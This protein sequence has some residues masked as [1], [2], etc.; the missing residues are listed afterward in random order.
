[1]T[2]HT[3]L[4]TCIW[5]DGAAEEAVD[6]YVS[7]FP[8]ASKGFVMKSPVDWPGGSAGDIVLVNFTL[9]EQS[10]QALNGGSG[11]EHTEAMS[12]S[13]SCHDQKEL[14]R[15][16]NAILDGGGSEIM[17]GWI[18]DRYGVRWQMVPTRFSK[19]MEEGSD[20]Q[21]EATFK[22]MNTMIKLDE[23]ELVVAYEKAAK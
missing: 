14:D 1:M 9:F 11:V 8:G 19:M 10:Y 17:C 2:Q 6:F 4:A 3:R 21:R 22:A 23:A 15:Y 7:V 13:V 20:A 12:L 18:K 5:F 16:W